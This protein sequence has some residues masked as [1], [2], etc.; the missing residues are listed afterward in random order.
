LFLN[1]LQATKPEAALKVLDDAARQADAEGEF[2]IGIAE[3][4]ASYA[5]Q[6]PSQRE[7]IHAKGLRVLGRVKDFKLRTPQ[8][9]VK[10]GDGFNLFGDSE[11]AAQIFREVLQRAEDQPLLRLSVRVK[12]AD[13]YLRKNDHKR[14]IE[15]LEAIVQEDPANVQAYYQLGRL[16]YEED[17]WA[18]AIDHLKKVMLF[19]PNFEPAH[20]D[21]AAAQ[22]AA[23]NTGDALAPLERASARF[24]DNFVVEYLLATAHTREKNWPQAV[25]HFTAAEVIART[26]DTNR[27][28]HGFYFQIG[29]A[30][31]R[32]GDRVQAAQYFQKCLELSPDFHEAQNYLGYMWAEHGENLEEARDLIA[33]AVKAE[34][35]NAAYLDSMGWVLFKL[36]Q[37]KEA[38]EYLLK[39]VAASEEPDATLYDHLGDIYAALNEADKARE[40]WRK[41]LAV[42]PS[43]LIQKKLDGAKTN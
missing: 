27:L 1:Y 42:E 6:F 11:N 15:Q 8:Q 5:Q 29:A 28:T 7:A 22:I 41:S 23:G 31:E 14:A 36:N 24:K 33:R 26:S 21:L 17:R 9:K 34:P 30:L 43:E 16:A 10:L 40:A 2:F 25:N 18:D 37:P 13:I 39:A 12:L 32:K 35:G 19:N 3:L 20:Y 4:Y 38:L